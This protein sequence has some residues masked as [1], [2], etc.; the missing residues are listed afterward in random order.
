MKKLLVSLVAV[1]MMSSTAVFAASETPISD[2]VNK[3]TSKITKTEKDANAKA[4]EAKKKQQEK[5]QKEKE[6]AAKE[7]AKQQGI[8]YEQYLELTSQTE[9]DLKAKISENCERN[10]KTS[11]VFGAIAKV[12]IILVD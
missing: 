11:F 4:A 9:E 8:T 3:Q 1:I 7:R 12:P 6:K 5:V 10:L 2:W